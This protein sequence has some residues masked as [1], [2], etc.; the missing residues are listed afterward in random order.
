MSHANQETEKIVGVTGAVTIDWNI[1]C[2]IPDRRSGASWI[3]ERS[4]TRAYWQ[5]GGAA[6][7]ADLVDAIAAWLQQSG[8]GRFSVRQIA[9]PVMD[10]SF[11][12]LCSGWN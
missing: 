8:R 11:S 7:L 6:L 12:A 3:E 4:H 9:A 2:A 10:A 1:A 5:R